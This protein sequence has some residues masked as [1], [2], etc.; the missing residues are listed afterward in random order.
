MNRPSDLPGVPEGAGPGQA[1]AHP[2]ATSRGGLCGTLALS[3]GHR[4]IMVELNIARGEAGNFDGAGSRDPVVRHLRITEDDREGARRAR[5]GWRARKDRRAQCNGPIPA[6]EVPTSMDDSGRHQTPQPGTGT[7]PSTSFWDAL[8]A[9]ECR[10]FRSLADSRTFASG[11]RL[12]REGETANHVIVILSGWTK[13]CVQANGTERVIAERGP[14]QLVGERAALQVSVRSATVI[15]METV[16]ALAVRTEDFAAFVS[17]HPAVLKIVESQVYERLT[18]HPALDGRG[19][20]DAASSSLPRAPGP[21]PTGDQPGERLSRRHQPLN[22]ENCTV[23]VT[24]VAA[25]G[26]VTRTNDD[27]R[28]I[29][30]AILEM[31]RLALNRIWDECSWEDRGDG[32]LLVVPPKIPTARVL[33]HLRTMLPVTLRRHNRIYSATAQIQLRVAMDVGPVISD[34]MGVSSDAIIRAARMRDAP[35]LRTAMTTKGATLGIIVSEF[36]YEAAVRQGSDLIDAADYHKVSVNVKETVSLPAWMEL[37]IPG[38]PALRPPLGA[39]PILGPHLAP[40]GWR[41]ARASHPAP[42]TKTN[43]PGARLDC[44]L[45]SHRAARSRPDAS[46]PATPLRPPAA[47]RCPGAISAGRSGC[48]CRR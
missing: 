19:H 17:A 28:I 44:R 25:F 3:L 15:A 34:T 21:L 14:G 16:Q 43:W 8:G 42:L 22:G 18:E 1:T 38:L 10:A 29:R 36:V 12:M 20:D 30:C 31:T 26:A 27:R 13:I 39:C 23:V 41:P 7:F 33:E 47:T 11:A 40:T 6:L 45:P 5:L 4:I 2:I 46:P 9:A 37:V 24:D 48:W 35:A 32:L